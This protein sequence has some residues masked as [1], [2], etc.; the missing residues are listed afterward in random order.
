MLSSYE[1]FKL[2]IMVLFMQGYT[3]SEIADVVCIVYDVSS[4]LHKFM[5]D[6]INQM[7]M[8]MTPEG[9]QCPNYLRLSDC[10][11]A[12]YGQGKESK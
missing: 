2:V 11:K 9:V 5:N 8:D 4:E 10:L 6:A 12:K 3:P 7:V 1:V